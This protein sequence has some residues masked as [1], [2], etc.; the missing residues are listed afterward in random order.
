MNTWRWYKKSFNIT[1]K[2]SS[3]KKIQLLNYNCFY[4]IEKVPIAE[5]IFACGFTR[6]AKYN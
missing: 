5:I 4:F 2:A 1:L 6:S 3:L